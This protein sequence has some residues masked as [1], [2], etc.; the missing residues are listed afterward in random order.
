MCQVNWL[1][2]IQTIALIATLGVLIKYTKETSGLRKAA[3]DQN[4]LS[5]RPCITIASEVRGVFEIKNIGRSAAFNIKVRIGKI[6]PQPD[7][8]EFDLLEPQESK[9]ITFVSKND[10]SSGFQNFAVVD[11]E[12][13]N[14]ENQKYISQL[15]LDLVNRSMTFTGTRLLEN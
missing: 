7:P 4:E 9:R 5:L 3:N 14:I 8:E 1:D 10:D 15:N 12:Y 6:F 2:I 11:I 13:Q